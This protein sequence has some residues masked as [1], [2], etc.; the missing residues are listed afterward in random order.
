MELVVVD[1]PRLELLRAQQQHQQPGASVAGLAG[2]E[3]RG[4][5]LLAELEEE[6]QAGLDGDDGVN[7]H[8]WEGCGSC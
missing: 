6:E 5:G 2:G 8:V 3:V 7:V 4:K 1:A